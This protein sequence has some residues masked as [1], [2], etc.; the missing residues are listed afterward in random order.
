MDR[1]ARA[2]NAE[3][4]FT[5]GYRYLRFYGSGYEKARLWLE[6]AA[7]NGHA[8]AGHHLREILQQARLN[9]DELRR[10]AQAGEASSAAH[11]AV[12]CATGSDGLGID[13]QASRELY[14]QAATCSDSAEAQYNYAFMLL[15]GEGGPPCP[16]EALRWLET[17]ASAGTTDAA[18]LL[19][20]VYTEGRWG[21]G[22][23]PQQAAHWRT[24]ADA[25]RGDQEAPPG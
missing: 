9:R 4:Q 12:L 10:S 7:A 11:L 2:G 16:A 3:A 8:E 5:L 17:A 14:G 20:D 23:D 13:L 6:Q 15:L 25:E 18:R 24:R 1:A 22:A 21:I 19:A